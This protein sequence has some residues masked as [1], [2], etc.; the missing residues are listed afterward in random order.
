MFLALVDTGKRSTLTHMAEGLL[1]MAH[2][3][4][5]RHRKV[6]EA[7]E[8]WDNGL[9]DENDKEQA[10]RVYLVMRFIADAIDKLPNKAWTG[11]GEVLVCEA[12]R[13]LIPLS[14]GGFSR[15]GTLEGRSS[16]T[17]F[18]ARTEPHH[19]QLR[20]GSAEHHLG[21]SLGQQ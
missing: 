14:P 16:A 2:K 15:V 12:V 13:Q 8:Y 6:R 4:M 5:P 7:Q 18:S 9:R 20:F 21:S 10:D 11:G 3:R 19:T 17:P 1:R